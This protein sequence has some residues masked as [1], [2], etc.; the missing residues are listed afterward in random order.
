MEFS[1]ARE[2][3][4]VVEVET[5]KCY[6]CKE[7][8]PITEFYKNKST[9]SGLDTLCKICRK[10]AGR[11]RYKGA[12]KRHKQLNIPVPTEKTC[13]T[14]NEVKPGTHFH[15]N[16]SIA[17]GRENICSTCKSRRKNEAP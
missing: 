6:G 4:S 17:D 2:V 7:F 14:C 12:K 16:Y 10:A 15:I 3:K 11:K 5:G 9:R 13:R 8:K 1:S